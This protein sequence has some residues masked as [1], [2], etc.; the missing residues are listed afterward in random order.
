[1]RLG[2]GPC[3]RER[4]PLSF[5]PSRPQGDG[6]AGAAG[7]RGLP[8]LEGPAA[9][10]GRGRRRVLRHGH[11]VDLHAGPRRCRCRRWLRRRELDR[12]QVLR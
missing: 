6:P 4:L 11:R 9:G 3:A 7:G 2:P 10:R 8:A 12:R 5:G 1:S